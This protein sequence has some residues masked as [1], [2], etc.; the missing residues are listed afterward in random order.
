[1]QQEIQEQERQAENLEQFIQRA[2]RNST[3]TEL[4][5]YT[6]RELV[7]AVYMDAPD[8][9]SGKRKHHIH[10]CYDLIG[11]ISVDVLLKAEQT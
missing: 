8:K 7:N 9:S 3:L 5:P 1:M 4:T 10:I 6:L 11:F 2:H